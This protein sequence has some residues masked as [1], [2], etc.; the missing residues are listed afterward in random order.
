MSLLLL[1]VTQYVLVN[2]LLLKREEITSTELF[3]NTDIRQPCNWKALCLIYT[4]IVCLV[5]FFGVFFFGCCFVFFVVL[6]LL[7]LFWVFLSFFFF[8]RKSAIKMYE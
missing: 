7:L 6:F 5:L 2:V 1:L 3:D 4:D 8:L